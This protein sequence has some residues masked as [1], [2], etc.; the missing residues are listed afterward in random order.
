MTD[1][2]RFLAQL[3][4]KARTGN[5]LQPPH[6]FSYRLRMKVTGIYGI[7][8]YNLTSEDRYFLTGYC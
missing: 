2:R 6:F 3:P 5:Q 7:N 1:F 8:C 4:E